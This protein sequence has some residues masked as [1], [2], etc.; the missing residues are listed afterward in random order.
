MLYAYYKKLDYFSTEC[1]YS[2]NAY[3]GYAREFIK[4]LEAIRPSAILDIIKSGESYET[5]EN[6]SKQV[7]G[8]CEKCGYISSNKICQACVLL[9]GLNKSRPTIEIKSDSPIIEINNQIEPSVPLQ[10]TNDFNNN[11]IDF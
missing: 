9:E 8:T 5:V 3:R 7:L 10:K 1:T 6:N 4:D 2:P 11:D